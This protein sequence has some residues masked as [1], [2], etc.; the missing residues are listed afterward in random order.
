MVFNFFSA[1][2]G[3]YCLFRRGTSC[4]VLVFWFLSFLSLIDLGPGCSGGLIVAW[5]LAGSAACLSHSISGVWLR[6][7]LGDFCKGREAQGFCL[8][9]DI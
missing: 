2:Q 5:G 7:V 8:F 9:S 1:I 4:G 6:G 3:F